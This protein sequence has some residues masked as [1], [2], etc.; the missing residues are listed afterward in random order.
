MQNIGSRAFTGA[1]IETVYDE[2]AAAFLPRRAFTGAWIETNV[3]L[4][5]DAFAEGRAFT[6]AWIETMISIQ[7]LHLNQV[8]P[9][10]ARGLKQA[11]DGHV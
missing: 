8:A 6:G 1:W 2:K 11:V 4:A 3:T 9:S 5:D 7:C 10:Q